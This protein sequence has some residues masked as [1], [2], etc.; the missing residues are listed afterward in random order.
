MTETCEVALGLANHYFKSLAYII[1][2]STQNFPV[3]WYYYYP[4]FTEEE[5]NHKVNRYIFPQL[6]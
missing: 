5:M 6:Y 2:F 1:S 4:H 3:N